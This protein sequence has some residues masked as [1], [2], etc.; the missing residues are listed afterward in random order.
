MLQNYRPWDELGWQ[1]TD[2]QA[3]RL[4]A[5]K[6]FRWS[7]LATFTLDNEKTI[8][9]LV[10]LMSVQ[11]DFFRRHRPAAKERNKFATAGQFSL[12]PPNHA[13]PPR[14]VGILAPPPSG[15]C[16]CHTDLVC[17]QT[18]RAT[19]RRHSCQ[20]KSVGCERRWVGVGVGD[21]WAERMWVQ[22]TT[23]RETPVLLHPKDSNV[24]ADAV[25]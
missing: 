1:L 15:C 2:I 18:P 12:P 3:G 9:R 14:N 25:T 23:S 8:L 20:K 21:W 24:I 11:T 6:T 5:K 7:G 19:H 4:E 17:F 16:R 22:E 13:P 10:R